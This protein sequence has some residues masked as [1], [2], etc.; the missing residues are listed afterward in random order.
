M[1]GDELPV[2]HVQYITVKV[3]HVADTDGGK[4]HGCWYDLNGN[5]ATDES[6]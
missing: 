2:E 4:W 5:L 6:E 1:V 3:A